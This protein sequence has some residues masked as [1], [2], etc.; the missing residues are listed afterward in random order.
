MNI[1][2]MLAMFA[3]AA[4][5][6]CGTAAQAAY[7]DKP[8]RMIVPFAAGGGADTVARLFAEKLAKELGVQFIVENRTGAGGNIGAAYV[9]RSAPDGY[10]ILLSGN[11]M[12]TA[13]A[14]YK[15][16]GYDTL[17]DF[18][19][20]SFVTV[21]PYILITGAQSPYKSLAD[22]IAAAKGPKSLFYATTGR[23]SAGHLAMEV[24]RTRAG[25]N[26]EPI[27][28][29]GGSEHVQA[30]IEGQIACG[31]EN[32]VNALSFIQSGRVRALAT[33]GPQRSKALP[34]VPTVAESGFPGFDV[35]VWQAFYVP[36]ATPPQVIERLHA[37]IL[38]S[39]KDPAL[40]QRFA[41]LNLEPFFSPTVAD[42]DHYNREEVT[43]WTQV[44]HDA[45]IPPE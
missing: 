40:L 10:T 42:A 37:A 31:F 13:N 7:P 12:A 38:A 23:G 28:Y 4:P 27:H 20:V 39:S 41:T 14:L 2:H 26:V 6:A 32:I 5:F 1:R 35:R 16:P 8:I 43:R 33:S 17:K 9:A 3:L 21:S 30:E 11:S 34:D 19:P 25:L 18:K 45:N 36:A 22:V 29:K 15:T 44:V 24:L